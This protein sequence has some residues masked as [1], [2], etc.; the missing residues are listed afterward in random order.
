[1]KLA[2]TI[3]AG[4]I[5]LAMAGA[6]AQA[7]D[8][9]AAAADAD[10]SGEIVVTATRTRT[11]SEELA[12]PVIVITRAEIERS[13]AGDVAE[14]LA[15]HSGV[16]IART[17]GPGQPASIFLSGTDSDHTT[18]L[19]DGVRINPGTIGGAAL[20]NIQPES[21]ERI[22]I[23]KGA[24]SSL[25]GTDA[26]GGVVNIITRAGAASGASVYGS[27]G[28]YGT[29]VLAADAGGNLSDRLAAGGSL[30]YERS[31]GFPP[32]RD[33]SDP[34]DYN[35]TSA[36]AQLRFAASDALGLRAQLW[37]AE[38]KSAYSDFGTAASENFLDASYAAGADWS[39]AAGRNARITLSRVSADVVQRDSADYDRTRRNTLDAQYGW[40]ANGANEL[41][42][43]AVVSSEHTES[44]SGSA[45]GFPTQ[46]DVH[47]HA[48][49]AYAQDQLHSGAN[50]LLLALGY[51]HHETFGS[52]GTGNIEYA[53]TLRPGLR[54]TLALGTAFHA[55]DSTD[56]FGFGGNPDL[57][58]ER[59]RQGRLGLRWIPAA[60][61]EL[62]LSAFENRVDGLI[63]YVLI[64]PVNFIYQAQNVAQSR[65]RGADAEYRWHSGPWQLRG[66]YSIQ[67]P[68]NLTTGEEL[69]RRA[70]RNA[71]ASALY[72]TARFSADAGL[73]L[74]GPRVDFGP[75]NL[76]GYA[77]LNLGCR[78]ELAPGW[79]VQLRLDNA[80]DRRY[81]LASGYN[82]AGRALTLAMRYR[83]R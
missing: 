66:S 22:E 25:Y 37:R 12:V 52:R 62:R 36:N 47:T 54:G 45:F 27:V 63:Q 20:Q 73:Q 1:M 72:E 38:G 83:M 78:Y 50:D 3:W 5:A 75:V 24:R 46:Y 70:R 6:C 35:N 44:L 39:G 33:A 71:L 21:I 80:L 13:L 55:P 68:R 76:G 56:R 28:R 4:A 2:F 79:S 29:T 49:L 7:A 11:D 16:E 23:I 65:I 67:D 10:S 34:G 77:L 82:T 59:S 30:A 42:V 18:V 69:L 14:L 74:A 32:R 64:D 57:Q 43:G 8:T 60:S 31:D 26:I 81:E 41:T 58:P 48:L 9:P 17:G 61:Q 53:R 15:G 40:R 19:L 51:T